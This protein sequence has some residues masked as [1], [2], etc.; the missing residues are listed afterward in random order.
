ML[1]M[2]FF[3]T[4]FLL[5][6]L[7][8]V[9]YGLWLLV[10]SVMAYAELF[11]LGITGA[12]IKYIAE[13]YATQAFD[14][15]RRLMATA[16]AM[17]ITLGL[18]VIGLSLALAPVF[19]RL[20][21]VPPGEA[22]TAT[23][24]VALMGVLM[25]LTMASSITW[26]VLHGLQR[27]DLDNLISVSS[28]ILT[29]LAIIVAVW[30]GGGV[31]G[32]VLASIGATLVMQTFA[33]WLTLRAAPELRLSLRGASLGEARTILHFGTALFLGRFAGRL[34]SQTDDIVIGALLPV[35]SIAPYSVA[36]RLG[37]LGDT[38][39]DQFTKVLEPL[40]S[41]LDA[42]KDHAGLRA[43]HLTST[44]Y[45]AIS[46]VACGLTILSVPFLSLWVGEVL[47]PSPAG[48]HHADAVRGAGHTGHARH[49]DRPGHGA[50]PAAGADGAGFR[51]GQPGAVDP[52]RSLPG[53][54][55]RGPGHAY[56]HLVGG[57]AAGPA[58]G[59]GPS[60]RGRDSSYA[61]ACPR[62]RRRRP[63]VCGCSRPWPGC[64]PRAG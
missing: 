18:L 55:W 35:A 41:Q 28:V 27:F 19:P 8:P 17:Y 39:T 43:L 64:V 61:A 5:S 59:C 30:L 37:E 40:A 62:C 14:S 36:Q 46:P 2:G 3:L 60:V 11:D 22:A 25:G 45:L 51:R 38:L 13:H 9:H 49:P 34:K 15:A 53:P 52:S 63:C 6:R 23:R 42:H 56:P 31:L 24:L 54:V 12:V 1:A 58:Y 32:L 4:P 10:G 57:H 29:N 21:Q 50:P 47:C 7:G 44:G 20:F 48:G 16:L 33:L 26:S